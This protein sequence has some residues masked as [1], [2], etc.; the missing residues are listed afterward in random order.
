MRTTIDTDKFYALYNPTNGKYLNKDDTLA[1]SDE[2]A[3]TSDISEAGAVARDDR[4]LMR[5]HRHNTGLLEEVGCL[6]VPMTVTKEIEITPE[7]SIKT[8]TAVAQLDKARNFV[9]ALETWKDD[10]GE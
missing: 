3:W 7:K 9:T 1:H 10:L 4:R 6:F 8:E 5:F 2:E